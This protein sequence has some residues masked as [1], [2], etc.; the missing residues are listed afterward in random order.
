MLSLSVLSC[1]DQGLRIPLAAFPKYLAAGPK[2]WNSVWNVMKW[3]LT[4]AAGTMPSHRH[5]G[6]PFDKTDS[7][8]KKLG[9]SPVAKG[10]LL[11]IR[12]DCAFYKAVFGLPGWQEK[13]GCFWKCCMTPDKIHKVSSNSLWRQA[14]NR[15]DHWAAVAALDRAT[16]LFGVPFFGM[17]IICLGWLHIMDIGV[18]LHW[19]GSVFV[20]LSQKL[21]GNNVDQRCKA[22][23]VSMKNYNKE[24]AIDSQMPLLK[25]SMLYKDKKK[26]SSSTSPKLGAKAGE[27]KG[28]I[29]FSLLQCTA[30]VNNSASFEAAV[31]QCAQ[32]FNCQ[33]VFEP[34]ALNREA[35][36]FAALYVT[37]NQI[38][39]QQGRQLFKVTPKLHLFLEMTFH[40]SPSAGWTHRDED[41]GRQMIH[42]T[43]IVI[44]RA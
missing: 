10:I 31:I 26:S 23:H 42:T 32:H 13:K 27:A 14:H 12:G 33:Q 11:Q 15:K 41:W 4:W 35:L 21:P 19:L 40:P 43:R 34:S 36:K 30:L 25:A 7:K 20:L 16:P 8:R 18:S 5:D 28:L 1:A 29:L 38:S 22:L 17:S 24:H 39:V 37:L 44:R 6:T 2:T 9:L 3:S